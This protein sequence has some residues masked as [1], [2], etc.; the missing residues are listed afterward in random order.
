MD[1]DEVTAYRCT[2]CGELYAEEEDA[3]AC[4]GSSEPIDAWACGRC[5]SVYE[6]REE[7]RKCCSAL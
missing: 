2:I 1:E 6:G 5:G 3:T 4:H 7:A